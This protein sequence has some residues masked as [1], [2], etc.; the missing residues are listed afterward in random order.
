ME[1]KRDRSVPYV[2]LYNIK[3]TQ[4]VLGPLDVHFNPLSAHAAAVFD[5][6]AATAKQLLFFFG[7][8]P[9]QKSNH[10]Q[11]LSKTGFVLKKHTSL[12]LPP[13]EKKILN[14]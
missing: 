5:V 6:A 10:L 7:N 11:N 1:T 2:S 14:K 12:F 4:L 13:F 8:N 3:S 9:N